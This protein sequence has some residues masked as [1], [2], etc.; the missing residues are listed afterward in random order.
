MPKKTAKQVALA[1]LSSAI[2]D[3]QPKPLHGTAAKPGIVKG[4]SQAA[5]DA[6][7]LC[8]S[9]GW[10]ESTGEFQ[11]KGKSRKE[12]YR[13]TASGVRAAIEGSETAM[14]LRSLITELDRQG[15][16]LDESRGRIDAAC[17][18]LS[19]QKS[20]VEKMLDQV[21]PPEL[22]ACGSVPAGGSELSMRAPGEAAWR[23]QAIEFL[24]QYQQGGSAPYCS[25]PEL[26]RSV[27]APA[28][29]SIG[30]FHDGVRE[31]ARGRRIRLH[32]FTDAH[33]RLEDEEY[34]L[35][36][37]REIKYYVEAVG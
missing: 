12:L 5:K 10:I 3:P 32:P 17:E 2:A 23:E 4:S 34:A 7:A 9:E 19:Q 27:A 13:V 16:R 8:K 36:A 26:Y 14:L 33:H 37:G 28:K 15:D 1:A 20:I 30:A 6:V 25:L 18:L 24:H 22:G 11:G 29:L 21:V 31:L 35:L